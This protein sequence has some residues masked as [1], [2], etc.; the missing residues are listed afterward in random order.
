M[1]S[2]I[3]IIFDSQQ[4]QSFLILEYRYKIDDLLIWNIRD[5]Q[6]YKYN[7]EHGKYCYGSK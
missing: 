6:I 3:R 7:I 5:N 1:I 4:I 2:L